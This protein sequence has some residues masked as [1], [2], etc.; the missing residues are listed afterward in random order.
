MKK[1]I[2]QKDRPPL[3]MGEEKHAAASF[4]IVSAKRKTNCLFREV[5]VVMKLKHIFIG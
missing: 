3:G 4:Y 5:D 1:L 2:F